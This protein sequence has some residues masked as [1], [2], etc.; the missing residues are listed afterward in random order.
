MRAAALERT[1]RTATCSREEETGE[2]R[3]KASCVSPLDTVH[4]PTAKQPS[5]ECIAIVLYDYCPVAFDTHTEPTHLHVAHRFVRL[6]LRFLHLR[7]DHTHHNDTNGS[8]QPNNPT[9]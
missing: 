3:S 1:E 5:C 4:S 6:C 2:T 9:L 7:E 8:A